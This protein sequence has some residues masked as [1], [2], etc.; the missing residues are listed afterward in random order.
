[1]NHWFCLADQN[2]FCITKG[3]QAFLP[4]SQHYPT[5]GRFWRSRYHALAHHSCKLVNIDFFIWND[6]GMGLQTDTKLLE[7]VEGVAQTQIWCRLWI[8]CDS[9]KLTV[10]ARN[11]L[12]SWGIVRKA[13][14]IRCCR[15]AAAVCGM[16]P[17]YLHWSSLGLNQT[18]RL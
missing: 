6:E 14:T 10:R 2:H 15:H 4:P 13:R 8:F 16:G 9:L 7:M 1:M 18:T 5:S 11:T 12:C 3:W 17:P